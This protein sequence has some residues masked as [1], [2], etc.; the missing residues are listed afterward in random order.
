VQKEMSGM[1]RKA[2]SYRAYEWWERK[3]G[4]PREA[5]EAM[6][7]N[8]RHCL[9]RHI[10]DF[11]EIEGKR[12]A[13]LLGSNGRKAIPL[14]LLGAVVTVIDIS[15]ENRRYALETAK[16]AGVEIDFIASDLFELD[17][18]DLNG[19]FD[20]VYLEG[21]ILHYFSDLARF[22]QIAA[23]LLKTGGRLILNDFHPLRRMLRSREDGTIAVDGDYFDRELR[24][25]TVAYRNEFPD[26]DQDDFPPVLIRSWTLGDIV[27]GIAGAGLVVERLT[28]EPGYDGQP[29]VPG[30]FTLIAHKYPLERGGE[31]CN[32]GS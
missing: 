21:G 13:N 10:D 3:S 14:A 25:G 8:P 24:E 5:A 26:G 15:P 19:T 27:T 11:G 16:E 9:R 2:W 6:K 4:T 23:E 31:G 22:A 29:T 17:R 7:R 20:I 30:L 1:N 12:I 28:E 18:S 32:S